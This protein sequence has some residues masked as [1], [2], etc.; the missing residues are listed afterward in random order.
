MNGGASPAWA[1]APARGAVLAL[2]LQASDKENPMSNAEERYRTAWDSYWSSLSGA[3]REVFWDSDPE[4]G[5]GRD[6]RHW[7]AIAD[8]ALPLLDVGCGNGTQTRFLADRFSRVL[9]LDV[10]GEAVE[11]ARRTHRAPGLEFRTLDVIRAEEA[12][13]L[14]AEIGD[15]NVYVRAVLHQLSPEHRPAAVRSLRTLLGARGT[16]FL[17][18]LA[19]TV[20]AYFASLADPHGAP[21]PGLARVKQHGITPGGIGDDDRVALFPADRFERLAEGDGTIV[22]THLLPEGGVAEA[23]MHFVVL[24]PRP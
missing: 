14:H 24:R 5:A 13:A 3:P 12:A 10:S 23:P 18:E 8:P 21:P 2:T 1:R 7:E 4:H 17:V 15:A 16:L 6:L 9:G 19:P 11:L 22:T 20:G